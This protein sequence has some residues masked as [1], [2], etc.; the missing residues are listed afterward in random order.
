MECAAVGHGNYR[1]RPSRRPPTSP[2]ER[3]DRQS[4]YVAFFGIYGVLRQ[5]RGR[6]MR[7]PPRFV[8]L[9]NDVQAMGLVRCRA[10]MQDLMAR[11]LSWRQACDRER[12]PYHHG[13]QIVGFNERRQAWTD[14]PPAGARLDSLGLWRVPVEVV[15]GRRVAFECKPCGCWHYFTDDDVGRLL[16]APC[17]SKASIL[18]NQTFYVEIPGVI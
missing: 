7:Q 15:D 10:A 17:L 11:G 2:E 16:I 8:K 4:I 13:A 12:W 3:E 6:H 5:R 1:D 18:R 9:L 14:L